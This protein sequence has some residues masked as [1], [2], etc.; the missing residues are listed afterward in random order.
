[1]NATQRLEEL[2]E[3]KEELQAQLDAAKASLHTNTPMPNTYS[4]PLQKNRHPPPCLSAEQVNATQRLEELLELKEE[5]QAQLDAAKASLQ[6]QEG[7][8]KAAREEGKALQGKLTAAEEAKSAAEKVGLG[9]CL[10]E[11]GQVSGCRQGRVPCRAV[12]PTH[13]TPTCR[14]Q[15]CALFWL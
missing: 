11:E 14:R 12:P 7:A 10:W 5:L 15:Q 13:H 9:L 2:L 8:L 1:V 6:E 3:P 4:C